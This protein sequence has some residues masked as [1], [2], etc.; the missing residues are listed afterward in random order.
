MKHG[1]FTFKL[2]GD[3]FFLVTSLIRGTERSRTAVPGFADQCLSHSA[4]VPFQVAK[5]AL[6]TLSTTVSGKKN[7]TLVC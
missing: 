4:T 5:V 7:L 2:K 1:Y 3:N 6:F